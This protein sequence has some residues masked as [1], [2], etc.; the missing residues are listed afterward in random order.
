MHLRSGLL[1]A[2]LVTLGIPSAL[3][4]QDTVVMKDGSSKTGSIQDA[5]FRG[6]KLSIQGGGTTSVKRDEIASITLDP[7]SLPKE[8]KAAEDEFVRGKYDEAVASYQAVL[9]AKTKARSIIRQD[10]FM[11][12][13][14]SYVFLDKADDAIKTIGSLIQEFPQSWHLEAAGA[15]QVQ[16]LTRTGKAAEAATFAET[17]E[18]RIAKLPE[19]TGLVERMKLLKAKAYL[20]AGDPKKAKA[21][22]STLAGGSSPG[23][24][25]AKVLLALISLADKNAAEAEKLFRDALKSVSARSD[26]AAAFNGLGSILLEKAKESKQTAD[27]MDALLLFLRTALVESPEA[28]EATEAHEAGIYNAGVCFQYLGELGTASAGSKSESKGAEAKGDDAQARNLQR[29]REWFR[30][31]LRDYPQSKY[32]ADAQTR[33]QKLGG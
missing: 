24:G 14:Q 32:A 5:D 2:A 18:S 1:I 20:D 19:S 16:I 6:L 15:L 29:A 33:L 11:R 3:T 8:F 7:K 23:A 13:A 26:R 30:R 17:E 22:A 28:G 27:I 12:Q 4:A 10:A 25:G 21:E 9:D 31:L